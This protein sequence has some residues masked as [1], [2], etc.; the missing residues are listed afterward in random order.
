MTGIGWLQILVYALAVF[1]LTKPLGAYMYRV[2]EGERK[3]LP[4]FFGPIERGLYRACGVD[5]RRE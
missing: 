1:A 4:R 5:A 2:F 3:P